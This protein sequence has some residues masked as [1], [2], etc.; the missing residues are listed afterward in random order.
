MLATL[1]ARSADPQPFGA[2]WTELE[3]ASTG[4]WWTTEHTGRNGWLNLVKVPRDEIVAFALYTVDDATLKMTAQLYP[5]YPD[6]ARE[7][8]LQIERDGDWSDIATSGVYELGW[9]AHFRIED[10]DET[11]AVAY[12]VVHPNGAFFEGLI[13]ANPRDQTEI[14]VASLSCNSSR[15]RG[16]RDSIVR[17]LIIQDPDILFFA[18][19]QSYDHREHTAGWLLWGQQFREIIRNRPT[20]AIPDDHDIGQPNLW[21]EG[22]KATDDR[23]GHSGGYYF[24]AKYVNMVQRAQTWHLPDAFDPTP[25]ARGIGVYFT[26]YNLGGIDFAIIEDRKFKSGPNGKIPNM[27]PRPDHINDPSYD[28]TAIDLPGLELLGDRQI[29]FLHQWSQDWSGADMKVVLSQT[30]FAG[31]V[32]LHGFD[33]DRLLAD[34]DSNGWPQAGRNAALTEIRRAKAFHLA[35]DQHIA[36]VTKHGIE[37]PGDGPVSFV[38]P[39]IVNTIYG[40][41]WWPENE[42]PGANPVEGSPLPWTGDYQDGFGNPITMMAYAN[43]DTFISAQRE[44]LPTDNY[45]DG[46]GLVRF[47]KATREAT[48]EC[49]PRFADVTQGD[50]GQYPGWPLTFALEDNDGREAVRYLPTLQFSGIE[51][52]VV[53]VVAEATGEV[54]YTL[55]INGTSYRPK[56]YA[57][58]NYTVRVGSGRPDLKT[59]ANIT[60]VGPEVAAVLP[61]EF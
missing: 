52:P 17:N 3:T 15:D 29:S 13:R 5:L 25:I 6:E 9:S 21:G 23:R 2:E 1:I 56:V 12:R 42:Q 30:N 35:G 48:M 47:N 43:P 40:R 49:W 31:A 45:G 34:L 60:A 7:V 37:A 53:Q 8:T 14:V 59:R 38:N 20:I 22:G 19:D 61:I 32:H 55:R 28:R 18:G 11:K 51:D 26:S 36:V 41:W 57:P 10:W 46:Y 54:L 39:A 33:R 27:G 16:D 44:R 50:S 58:G 24:P 4:E